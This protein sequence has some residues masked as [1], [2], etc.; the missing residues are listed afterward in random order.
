MKQIWNDI[1]THIS[2]DV[3]LLPYGLTLLFLAALLFINYFFNLEHSWLSTLSPL[4]YFL[5]I[6]VLFSILYYGAVFIKRGWR[7]F[8]DRA[9]LLYSAAT[10]LIA[11]LASS[12]LFVKAWTGSLSRFEAFYA[13]QLLY[14]SAGTVI[15]LVGLALLYFTYDRGKV[16]GFYG[17]RVKKVHHFAPYLGLLLMMLPL[18]LWASSQPHFLE[19]YPIFRMEHNR[20]VFGLSLTQMAAI[21]ESFYLL[22]FI[23]VE[24]VFRGILVIGMA[25]FL[26]KDAILPMAVIYCALHFNKP[27]GEAISSI[28]GGYILGV[29]AYYQRH[30][31]GGIIVHMG[32]AGIMELLAYWASS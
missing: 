6:G 11:S 1:K 14:N 29:I 7:I 26:G 4:G 21:F 10:L 19:T 31:T 9:F 15:A 27:L 17:L 20:P 28:F 22:D 23:R 13:S 24:L 3:R 32:V 8:Q 18:L 25:R 2:E 30:I 5:H 12:L 16:S